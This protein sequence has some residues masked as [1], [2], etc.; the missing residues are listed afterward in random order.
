MRVPAQFGSPRAG[1]L[2]L[3]FA[4]SP[5]SQVAFNNLGGKASIWH[6]LIDISSHVRMA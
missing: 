4:A 1:C 6:N 5:F 3:N 2:A